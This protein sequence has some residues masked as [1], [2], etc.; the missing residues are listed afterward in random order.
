ME[1]CP[2]NTAPTGWALAGNVRKPLSEK[3]VRDKYR[4]GAAKQLG[5]SA[6]EATIDVINNLAELRNIGEL[7][8]ALNP[9]GG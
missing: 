1:P 4:A 3:E 8:R 2:L 7:T 6:I 9:S 5:P